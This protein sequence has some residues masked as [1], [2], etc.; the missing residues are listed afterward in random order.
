[1]LA[2]EFSRF[3]LQPI[4]EAGLQTP[5]FAQGARQSRG[6]NLRI[7]P[8]NIRMMSLPEIENF[9]SIFIIHPCTFGADD[10]RRERL[11]QP[12]RV[13][14]A[15]DHVFNRARV[16]RRGFRRMLG[17][18]SGEFR[19]ERRVIAWLHRLLSIWSSRFR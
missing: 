4:G 10:A 7:V 3:D 17:V 8:Q 14:A 12:Q 9:I 5:A 2:D 11:Q 19:H 18:F 13:A 16:Q 15:V 6:D 1:L